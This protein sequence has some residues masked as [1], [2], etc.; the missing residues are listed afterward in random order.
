MPALALL[1]LSAVLI[2]LSVFSLRAARPLH[3]PIST[4][5]PTRKKK[6]QRPALP[7][8]AAYR[9]APILGPTS[10]HDVNTRRE[11][12]RASIRSRAAVGEA[13]LS[14]IGK[15]R[16]AI[17]RVAASPVPAADGGTSQAA[18]SAAFPAAA[19]SSS[20]PYLHLHL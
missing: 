18:V 7:Y 4:P 5:H 10:H 2:P 16:L 8:F 9:R 1:F 11:A 17:E 6:K 3:R 19:S 20:T 13:W 12:K 14:P 15:Q